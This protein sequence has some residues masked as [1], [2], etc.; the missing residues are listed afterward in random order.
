MN[1]RST[2]YFMSMALSIFQ[3]TN[4]SDSKSIKVISLNC[5]VKTISSEI[6]NKNPLSLEELLIQDQKYIHLITEEN[7]ASL[8]SDYYGSLVL[9]KVMD[10]HSENA[11]LLLPYAK[12]NFLAILGKNNNSGIT[13]LLKIIQLC[14][15]ACEEFIQLLLTSNI[16]EESRGFFLYEMVKNNSSAA[17]KILNLITTQQLINLASTR[18]TDN[19]FTD[20]AYA[21]LIFEIIKAHPEKAPF[22]IK[23]F[24]NDFELWA[25]CDNGAQMLINIMDLYPEASK[26]FVEPCVKLLNKSNLSNGNYLNKHAQKVILAIIEHFPDA[27]MHLILPLLNNFFINFSIN[28]NIALLYKML[29]ACPEAIR[30]VIPFVINNFEALT[31]FSDEDGTLIDKIINRYPN[32][33]ELFIEP[34]VKNFSTFD[35]AGNRLV[36][37]IIKHH[38]K[39]YQKFAPLIINRIKNSGPF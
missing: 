19:S 12:Q 24:I 13:V 9:I 27:S 26:D 37:T 36:S 4:C 2:I 10:I 29:E 34:A 21:I 5:T 39:A 18:P 15:E 3:L 6:A 23:P 28:N 22:L 32:T 17:Q 7:F 8:A 20:E 25:T 11:Y 14:P 1:A 31:H 35:D 16:S 30:L 33:A 38:P